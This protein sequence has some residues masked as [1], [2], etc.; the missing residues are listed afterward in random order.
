MFMGNLRP[1]STSNLA[2]IYICWTF[3]LVTSKLDDVKS[4]KW[5]QH[6]GPDFP[7]LFRDNW[8]FGFTT[9]HQQGEFWGLVLELKLCHDRF[10]TYFRM[11]VT[12]FELLLTELGTEKSFQRAACFWGK[13]VLF[14]YSQIP[15]CLVQVCVFELRADF[16]TGNTRPH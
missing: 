13:T 6:Q 3:T 14:H 15:V 9:R 16:Q 8:D 10:D 7:F 4:P 1:V 11:S 5:T 12:Q 2:N